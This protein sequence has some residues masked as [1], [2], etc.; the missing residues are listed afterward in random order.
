MWPW[1]DARVQAADCSGF[2]A[3]SW[4][5]VPEAFRAGAVLPAPWEALFAPLR[6]GTID[7]LV[8]VGQIGQ[9]L[10][11]RTATSSGHSHYINC[12]EGLDHLH[13]LRALV[14]AVVVGVGTVTAD[15]PQMTVR[16]VAGPN[17]ARVVIDPHG[18]LSGDARMLAGGVRRIVVTCE[19]ARTQMPKDI[20]QI[21]L[22]AERG[23]IAPAAIL[24]ALAECGFRRVM[25]EGGANTVSRFIAA[26]CMDRLHIMVAPLIL[27]DGPTA[28]GLAPL[29]RIDHALRPPVRAF[30]LGVDVLFDCDLTA[31]RE[32]I[33]RANKST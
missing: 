10:D 6:N 20:E 22:P 24:A 14:D 32:P 19:G 12:A 9:S 21:A 28:L 27:G 13:R 17:P 25:I 26:R 30:P 8:V 3:E 29:Q 15:N 23:H 16:R 7:G 33:G 4:V 31:H 11:G 18:R 2:A 5:G 1:R